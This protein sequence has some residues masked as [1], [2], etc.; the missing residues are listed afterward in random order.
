MKNLL[1]ERIKS[2][3]HETYVRFKKMDFE[4]IAGAVFGLIAVVFI[5]GYLIWYLLAFFLT[6]LGIGPYTLKDFRITA[7][8][9]SGGGSGSSYSGSSSSFSGGGGS[10]GGGGA[11]GSW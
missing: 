2:E 10:F 3:F 9:G 7:S 5:G 11:S 6:L 8:G 4:D 1:Y